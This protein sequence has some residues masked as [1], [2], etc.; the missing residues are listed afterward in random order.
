MNSRFL[1]KFNILTVTMGFDSPEDYI[2]N[3]VNQGWPT[4]KIFLELKKIAIKNDLRMINI[5]TLR[6][7]IN[8]LKSHPNFPEEYLAHGPGTATAKQEA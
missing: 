5:R 6:N 8:S 3:R 7:K 2:L 4:G 1:T